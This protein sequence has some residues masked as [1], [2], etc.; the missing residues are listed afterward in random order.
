[1]SVYKSRYPVLSPGRGVET[2]RAGGLAPAPATPVST[3]SDGTPQVKMPMPANV[4][5]N[6]YAKRNGQ[7]V[8]LYSLDDDGIKKMHEQNRGNFYNDLDKKAH[9]YAISSYGNS[10]KQYTV[11]S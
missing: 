8:L 10:S 11:D 1:M 5:R 9:R 3:E 4:W 2:L 7:I 6:I